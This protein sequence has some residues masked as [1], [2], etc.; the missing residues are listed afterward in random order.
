M[1]HLVPKTVTAGLSLRHVVVQPAFP[2]PEWRL[3]LVLRGPA[4]IDLTA[5]AEDEKH[6]FAVPAGVT[7]G[8]LS[9]TYSFSLRATRGDA[10]EEIDS[11]TLTIRPDLAQ[12]PAGHD[13]RSHVEKALDAIEAV[14]EK[15]ATLDQERY[16][17]NN[18]ELWRTPIGDLLRL[19]DVYRA[20]LN[21]MK[22]AKSGK[23]FGV[24]RVV[25]R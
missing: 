8:W 1:T 4:A 2:A 23:L 3:V 15:R 19:R 13:A 24:G 16:R 12:T 18:R 22:M 7:A 10:V 25:F 5:Q 17:I 11:G 14:L 9:G 20:E 6:L 21:R